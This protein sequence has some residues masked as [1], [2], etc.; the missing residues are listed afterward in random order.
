MDKKLNN[1]ILMKKTKIKTDNLLLRRE[2]KEFYVI[3]LPLANEV[4]GKVMFLHV[5]VCSQGGYDFSSCLV[6]CSFGEG[7]GV[8]VPGEGYGPGGYP[9]PVLTSSG[10]HRSGRYASYWNTFLFCYQ[11]TFATLFSTD[12]VLRVVGAA[13]PHGRVDVGVPADPGAVRR[14]GGA[15]ADGPGP[16][17]RRVARVFRVHQQVPHANT[18]RYQTKHVSLWCYLFN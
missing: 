8:M 9:L 11:F 7:G 17:G 4:H 3:L 5:F 15:R 14:G 18:E 2:L 1:Q 6:P 16:Q 13:E 10:G 12:D